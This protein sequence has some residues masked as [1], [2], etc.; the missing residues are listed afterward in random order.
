MNQSQITTIRNSITHRIE[1]LAEARFP[2]PK[3]DVDGMAEITKALVHG[4][5]VRLRPAAE[6]KRRALDKIASSSYSSDRS[7][8]FD[9]VFETSA[10]V[11][12][13]RR[14]RAA[15]ERARDK[16]KVKLEGL[17]ARILADCKLVVFDVEHGAALDQF[18]AK[19]EEL[20][21]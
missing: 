1:V 21:A 4:K 16:F 17:K 14:E 19:A 12:A 5:A 20:A 2:S 6:L 10:E 9:E 13:A 18:E 11:E 7:F 15:T 8:R 3:K